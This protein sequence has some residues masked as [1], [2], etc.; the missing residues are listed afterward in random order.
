[1]E[2]DRHVPFSIKQEMRD[3]GLGQCIGAVSWAK[4]RASVGTNMILCME[5]HGIGRHLH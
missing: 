4:M 3:I 1:M 2:R 5:G